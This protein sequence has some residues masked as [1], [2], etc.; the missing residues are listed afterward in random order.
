M[1]DFASELKNAKTVAIAGHVKPDGDC[2][3]SCLATYNYIATWFPGSGL[4][5]IKYAAAMTPTR[6]MTYALCRT[7]GIQAAWGR[8]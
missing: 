4:M 1:K 3:G 8:L 6:L 7:A 5:Q 2:V